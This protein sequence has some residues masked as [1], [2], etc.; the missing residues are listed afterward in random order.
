M[1]HQDIINSTPTRHVSGELLMSNQKGFTLIELLVVISII[2]LLVAILMPAL[3]VARQQAT[4]VVCLANCKT[5]ATTWTMYASDNDGRIVLGH[6]S[7]WTDPGGH[8]Y[9]PWAYSSTQPYTLDKPPLEPKF[10]AI[11]AGLLYEY[12]NTVEAYHCP[13]DKRSL[14]PARLNSN[15]M[16]GYRSYSIP[17]G[18]F[19]TNPDGGYGIIPHTTDTSIHNPSRKYVF[20]EEMDGRGSNLGSWIIHPLDSATPNSWIDPIAIWHNK[21]STLGFCDGHA[22]MH[23]WVEESTVEMA[24]NQSFHASPDLTGGEEGIDLRY[25]QRGY[26]YK[27]L[28]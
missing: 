19:G 5:L 15:T 20:I 2:A 24:E 25:M 12:I 18:L 26:A 6:T 16:G 23:R 1:I 4:G 11:R 13:A 9:K 28:D 7:E 8:V 27:A 14:E 22:E 17:G 10:E 3:N 21:K